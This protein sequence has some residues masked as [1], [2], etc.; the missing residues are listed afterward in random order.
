MKKTITSLIIGLACAAGSANVFAEDLL[1]VYQQALENDPVVLKAAAQFNIAK[2]DIEQARATLLPQLSASASFTD[3]KNDREDEDTGRIFDVDSENT[4]YSA[5][6]SM[7]IY[8]HD[9]WLRLDSAKKSAH[10]SDISYQVAKQD[11]IV[12]VTQAYFTLLS[13][14]DDLENRSFFG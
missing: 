12:R 7:E 5:K 13:A 3:S 10:R 2:E 11:L 8:H 9:S 6:L 1:T 4:S 14:K